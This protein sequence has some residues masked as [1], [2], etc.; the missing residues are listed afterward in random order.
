MIDGDKV[1]LVVQENVLNQAENDHFEY[2]LRTAQI[3]LLVEKHEYIRAAV[4][5]N[6]TRQ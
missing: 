2:H 1:S 3:Y 4:H 6:E 5:V